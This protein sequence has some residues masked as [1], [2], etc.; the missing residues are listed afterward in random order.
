[1]KE[2]EG[3][4]EGEREREQEGGKRRVGE[5]KAERKIKEGDKDREREVGKNFH[6]GG[7]TGTKANDGRQVSR[8]SFWNRCHKVRAAKR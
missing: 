3:G 5:I 6:L 4:R 2:K 8:H 7:R 1:M